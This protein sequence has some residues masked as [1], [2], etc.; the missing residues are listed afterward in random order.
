MY[1]PLSY[2]IKFCV[3]SI[4]LIAYNNCNCLVEIKQLLEVS[5]HSLILMLLVQCCLREARRVSRTA[6]FLR[7]A[8]FHAP[9]SMYS[10]FLCNY[11]CKHF[12]S[13]F[14]SHYYSYYKQNYIENY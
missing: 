12:F 1:C 14:S 8:S 11:S 4:T 13:Y 5:R 3:A 6:V 10:A 2:N 7:P 9:V